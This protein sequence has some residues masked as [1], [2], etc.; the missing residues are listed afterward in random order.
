MDDIAL[1]DYPKGPSIHSQAVD[2]S[3]R[4]EHIHAAAVDD[5]DNGFAAQPEY[6][7]G[8]DPS[9]DKRDMYRLGRKQELK[10]R[11]KYC[12][13]FTSSIASNKHQPNCIGA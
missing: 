2:E 7:K 4:R 13:C 11:F 8:Y 12:E 10:R 3:P 5:G 9:H 1:K 6:G